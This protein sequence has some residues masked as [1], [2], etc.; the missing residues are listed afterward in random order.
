MNRRN[1]KKQPIVWR[2]LPPETHATGTVKTKPIYRFSGD[3]RDHQALYRLLPLYSP[4]SILVDPANICNFGCV[5]CPTG[6]ANLVRDSKRAA[7]IMSLE[8]FRKIADD[9][10]TFGRPLERLLLHKDGEPLLN[11]DLAAMIQIARSRNLAR[12][13]ETTT[14][15]ALLNADRA[16]ELMDAGLDRLRISVEHISNDGYHRIARTPITYDQVLSNTRQAFELRA[17]RGS[18]MRIYAKLINTGLSTEER[19]KFLNDFSAY[20]DEIHIDELMGW[21]ASSTFD[22]TLGTG[23]A[24]AMS[25]DWPLADRIVCPQPFYTMAINFNGI[26]SVCCVDWTL[27]TVIG[28]VRVSSLQAI[29]NGEAMRHFRLMHLQ[30]RRGIHGACGDCHYIR[31]MSPQSNLDSHRD[32]LLRLYGSTS[33]A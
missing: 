15:A 6:H 31:G 4:L 24:L 9:I 5:F 17:L 11:S 12:S 22:F 18:A 21:S 3:A 7:G 33:H 16:S 13:I 32:E 30:A 20:C 27:A 2:P 28:D 29:W 14:N 26:V 25:G 19:K 10:A 1:S 23:P 8:L